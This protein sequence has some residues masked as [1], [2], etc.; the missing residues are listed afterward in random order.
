MKHI[1][2]RKKEENKLWKDY[3][4][5]ITRKMKQT[6]KPTYTKRNVWGVDTWCVKS[7]N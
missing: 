5:P 4:K 7:L 1:I 2:K 3:A 6:L